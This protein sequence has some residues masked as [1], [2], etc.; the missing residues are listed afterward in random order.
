MFTFFNVTLID[1][2]AYIPLYY[3]YPKYST[4]ELN[5]KLSQKE[6]QNLNDQ[7][8]SLTLIVRG[9]QLFICLFVALF[10]FIVYKLRQER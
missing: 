1:F 2:Y 9:S 5:S 8:D 10:V 7:V 3:G 6:R 4:Y